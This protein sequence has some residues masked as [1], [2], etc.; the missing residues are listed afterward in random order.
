MAIGR[1][2]K[3]LNKFTSKQSVNID[4]PINL[5]LISEQKILP[6]GE[7]NHIVNEVEQFN[8]ERNI[9]KKYRLIATID[10]LIS[11][12]LF[13]I[14][15]DKVPKDFGLKPSSD[16]L[17]DKTHS[18]GWEVFNNNIFKQDILKTQAADGGSSPLAVN[19]M[20]GRED[21]TY[22][23][24]IKKSLKEINGWFGFFDPDD[25][26][27]GDCS[28]YD[29]EPTRYKF[30]FN[31]N[32]NKN[33]DIVVTYPAKNDTTHHLVNN[34]LLITTMTVR[35]FGGRQ[36]VCLGTA[37]PNNLVNG[38]D[39]K[40]SNM[41]LALLNGTF[42]VLSLGLDNGDYKK[43]FFTIAIDATIPSVASLVGIAFNGG[44]LKRLYFGHEVEYYIRKFRK[45]KMFSTQKEM[46]SDDYE[47][48]PVGF[49]VTSFK[50]KL[51]QLIVNEDIDIENLKDNL[52]RPITEIYVTILKTDSNNTFTK[53]MDGFDMINIE[54]NTKT[55]T[56]QFRKL[57]N[58][59]KIHTLGSSIKAPFPSHDPLDL[60]GNGIDIN[61]NE[62]YGD[63]AEY[64]QYEVRETILSKVKH[65]F[66]TIDRELTGDISISDSA[67]T[68]ATKQSKTI[69]GSRLEGYMYNPHH[70]I[71]IRQYSNY[72][73]QGNDKTINIPEYRELIGNNLYLWR[74]LL[75][76]GY[77]DGIEQPIEFPFLNGCHYLYS[78]ICFPVRRQDPFGNFDLYYNGND[79]VSSPADISGDAISDNFNVNS[80]DYGC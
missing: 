40:L 15:S 7:I 66:N 67:E 72:V 77:N 45:I 30:D 20:L 74:D 63:I 4:T 69:E 26:K 31:N 9:S 71:Q 10:P 5:P 24:A 42:S 1:I 27:A 49:A 65:R 76:I 61:D 18:Y 75:D 80:S 3:R 33:W 55:N 13:N 48:Y 16:D 39:I 53:V 41:P 28:F 52:G 57:G 36:L 78:N 68:D 12:V 25:T 38:D 11:N 47:L 37:V 51:F 6:I 8:K 2:Q 32:V 22:E 56:A 70:R 29:M 35:N 54:G 73:E 34:G 43:N 58:I 44:R 60:A 59:R 19:P 23:Q 64:S 62:F 50:D 46:E 14:S 21:Y 17:N 79:K